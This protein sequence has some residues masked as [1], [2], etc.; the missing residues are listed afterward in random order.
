[1]NRASIAPA[2]R[3]LRFA[4]AAVVLGAAFLP[5]ARARANVIQEY[6]SLALQGD[7]RGARALFD[8]VPPASRDAQWQA[9]E[10]QFAARFERCDEVFPPL[11]ASPFVGDVVR[12]YRDYRTRVLTGSLDAASG[13]SALRAA[14][15]EALAL[16]RP[17]APRATPENVLDRMKEE[18]ESEGL[19]VLGGVTRP[20]FDLMIWSYQEP[21]TYDCTLTDSTQRV[22]V[23]FLGDFLVHGW[24]HFA[25]FGRAYTGG[26]ATKENLFCLRDDYDLES[27][28]FKVSYLQHEGRHF[29]DYALYPALEQIDLE[30]RGKLTELAFADS[31]LAG[32]IDHFAASGALNP[33]APHAYANFCVVRDVSRELFG[34]EVMDANDAR[35]RSAP[36]ERIHAAARTVLE[37]SSARLDAAGAA[38]TRGVV[39]PPD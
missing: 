36:N 32:L 30:Y 7:V 12:V 1:M 2:P 15:V 39:R 8:A 29:A 4:L 22:E 3:P 31:S 16:H 35:W 13:E 26:W 37:R 11:E 33:A 23:V 34:E 10:A 14:L 20:Y 9:L 5:G 28:K 38:T 27:E 6:C 21:R 25:T 19:H 24:S 18:I 17:Q